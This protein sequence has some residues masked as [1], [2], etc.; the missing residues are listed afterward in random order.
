ML[1]ELTVWNNSLERSAGRLY[2]WKPSRAQ[3]GGNSPPEATRRSF[4]AQHFGAVPANRF[5]SHKRLLSQKRPAGTVNQ[6]TSSA[7]RF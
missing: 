6:K 3:T 5:L 1:S 7:S 2:Q 4:R